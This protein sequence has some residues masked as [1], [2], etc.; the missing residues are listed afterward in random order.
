MYFDT[1]GGSETEPISGRYYDDFTPPPAPTKQGYIFAGWDPPLPIYEYDDENGNHYTF[2]T[3]I[4]ITE[5][6]LWTPASD[7]KY[8]VEYYKHNL[9]DD[10]FTLSAEDTETL[11]G[12][13]EEQTT[14]AAKKLAGLTARPVEQQTIAADGSTV[15]KVYYDRD[16]VYV[17]KDDL[18]EKIAAIKTSCRIIVSGELDARDPTPKNMRV[19]KDSARYYNTDMPNLTPEQEK[20]IEES[21][22]PNSFDIMT[23]VLNT[24]SRDIDIIMDLSN[25]TGLTKVPDCAFDSIIPH[26]LF[27]LFADSMQVNYG[28]PLLLIGRIVTVILPDSVQS[29]GK[30]AFRDCY[31]LKE[32]N[33]PASLTDI[34]ENAFQG[35]TSLT[36]VPTVGGGD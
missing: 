11:T 13:T 12:I 4:P 31:K 35:C 20:E 33:T 26:P 9:L 34:G 7:T 22:L 28:S 24:L 6:V 10:G 2:S 25:V 29:I 18:E 16:D 5:K 21:P 3:L 1:D 14:V 19:K 32:I 15:V 36:N 30:D 8:T 17:T 23:Y 27:L